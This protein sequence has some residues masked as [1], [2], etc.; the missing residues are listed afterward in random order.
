VTE[1]SIAGAGKG[2]NAIRAA[3][4]SLNLGGHAVLARL[5][6]TSC[7]ECARPIRWWNRRVWAINREHCSHLQCWNGQLFLKT[8]V[9]VMSEEIRHSA[10]TRS[11][12]I[13]NDSDDAQLH[14]LR[15]SARALR[16]RV[17]RLEAQ[18]QQAEEVATKMRVN[19]ARKNSKQS[20]PSSRI[21]IKG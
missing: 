5:R 2:A 10:P 12:P 19:M 8:Y 14:E 16:E 11:R 13:D 18:L 3:W 21:S 6:T 1:D 17:E 7:D 9:Q 15:A 4:R 20:I